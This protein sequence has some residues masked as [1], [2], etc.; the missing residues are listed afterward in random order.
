[1][2]DIKGPTLASLVNRTD[3]FYHNPSF[4]SDSFDH[5][6][7]RVVI[8]TAHW[9][10]IEPKTAD[11]TAYDVFG[12]AR[13]KLCQKAIKRTSDEFYIR[14]G[15][16][17]KDTAPD[18]DRL[19]HRLPHEK[20]L[21]ALNCGNVTLPTIILNGKITSVK[22]SDNTS[23]DIGYFLVLSKLSWFILPPSDGFSPVPIFTDNPVL[24]ESNDV[25]WERLVGI[26]A[27]R[28]MK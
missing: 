26:V 23:L 12:K 24:A 22:L 28:K 10:L 16:K 19:L 13:E 5:L 14:W 20:Y 9:V 7:N 17:D 2:A 6:K 1:M 25:K 18:I 3:T 21:P 11:T 4:T 27:Q 15:V 8:G